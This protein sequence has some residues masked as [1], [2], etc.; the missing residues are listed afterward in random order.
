MESFYKNKEGIELMLIASALAAI[1]QLCWKMSSLYGVLIAVLGFLLYGLGAVLMILAYR[2][3]SISVL[4]PVLSS[5]YVLSILIGHFILGE[6][7]SIT[8]VAGI[9]VIIFGIVMIAGGDE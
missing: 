9:F 1:G 4:Q 5:N 3:G 7:I 2:Y 8:K 6:D